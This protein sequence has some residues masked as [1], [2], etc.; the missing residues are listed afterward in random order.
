MLKFEDLDDTG[1]QNLMLE[2]VSRAKKDYVIGYIKQ[3]KY[4]G[5]VLTED[6]YNA[7]IVSNKGKFRNSDSKRTQREKARYEA[8]C[9]VCKNYYSA[10]RFVKLDPYLLFDNKEDRILTAWEE[11]AKNFYNIKGRPCKHEVSYDF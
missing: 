5:K 1:L 7:W 6:E 9:E 11:H 2:I 4:F 10:I 3:M 8:F